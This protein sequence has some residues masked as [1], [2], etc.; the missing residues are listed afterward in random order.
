MSTFYKVF[1]GVSNYSMHDFIF[2]HA[3]DF[4][5]NVFGIA[6]KIP[7]YTS[8]KDMNLESK[9]INCWNSAISLIY[10]MQEHCV[11]K[12]GK[13]KTCLLLLFSIP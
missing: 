2:S 1:H 6:V 13:I 11:Y 3:E 4:S 8:Y 9:E 12:E 5:F 7:L 10:T